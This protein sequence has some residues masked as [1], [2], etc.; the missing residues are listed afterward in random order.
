MEE[1]TR[2]D[3][4]AVLKDLFEGNPGTRRLFLAML[5]A[6]RDEVPFDVAVQ[7]ASTVPLPKSCIQTPQAALESLM[8]C[9]AVSL[10]I[11]VDGVEYGGTFDDLQADESIPL[12]AVIEYTVRI[13]QEGLA[14]ARAYSPHR[15]LREL[16]AANP[17]RVEG[18]VA[19]MRL[20][21]PREGAARGEIARF[22]DANPAFL[23]A[24]DDAVAPLLPAYYTGKLE[25]AGAIAW[26]G[27]WRLTGEGR[28]FLQSHEM[29]GQS[30]TD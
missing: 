8:R 4:A 2:L 17:D 23:A 20:C 14:A 26:E 9:E 3:P 18:L 11:Y 10:R 22:L 7:R 25:E 29:S 12:D 24:S 28:Q 15:K 21:A 13:T 5:D 16:F 1:D 19:V 6:A 27:S 30:T